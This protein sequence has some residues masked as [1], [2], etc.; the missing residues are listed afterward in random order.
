M[1]VEYIGPDLSALDA[2]LRKALAT[3]NYTLAGPSER[4]GVSRYLVMSGK[5]RVGQV[6]VSPVGP[7]LTI[8]L[9]APGATGIALFIWQDPKPAN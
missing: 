2:D 8:K 9:G 4:D 6:A 3:K 1:A 7:A 5:V